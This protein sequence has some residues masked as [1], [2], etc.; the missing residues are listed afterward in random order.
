MAA[1]MRS[2][3]RECF[4]NLLSVS[5]S[6]TE[7]EIKS[8]YRKLALAL[9]PDRNG[10]D[11]IKT[12]RFR[13]ATDAYVTLTDPR[14]RT[15]Y[16]RENNIFKPVKSSF[17]APAG[18]APPGMKYRPTAPPKHPIM[19]YEEWYRMQYGGGIREKV[20]KPPG[21]IKGSRRASS[22]TPRGAD[23]VTDESEGGYAKY[24]APVSKVI[25]NA[26]SYGGTSQRL[27]NQHYERNGIVDRMNERR[28]RRPQRTTT[29]AGDAAEEG[30]TI[31]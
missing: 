1:S 22:T 21:G 11:Q 28:K 8:S 27:V 26:M 30:C 18:S 10:G 9:H 17:S 2:A 5:R 14:L 4:Y 23:F 31:M 7:T 13:A 12:A 6:A 3:P 20:A 15:V 25:G 16:D 24:G 19:D 29:A